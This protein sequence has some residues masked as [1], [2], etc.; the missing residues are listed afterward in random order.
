MDE[1]QL[2]INQ[3]VQE[4]LR[5]LEAASLI[6]MAVISALIAAHPKPMA[7][8]ETIEQSAQRLISNALNTG[9][10]DDFVYAQDARLQLFLKALQLGS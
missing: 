2:Q 1:R 9:V 10:Q 4:R 3:N 8:R 7:L 6:D 5:A